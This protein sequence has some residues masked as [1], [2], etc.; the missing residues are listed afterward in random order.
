MPDS[1]DPT[2]WIHGLARAGRKARKNRYSWT[3]GE[4]HLYYLDGRYS[5][6]ET[7]ASNLGW[8]YVHS[9]ECD[10]DPRGECE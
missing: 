7:F 10:W 6:L 3:G 4:E 2:E 1:I 8:E 5:A 9:A